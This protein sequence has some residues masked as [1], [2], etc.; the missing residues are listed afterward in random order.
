MLIVKEEKD[1]MIIM[2]LLLFPSEFLCGGFYCVQIFVLRKL[3][4]AM[5]IYIGKRKLSSINYIR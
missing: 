1:V 5:R 4:K 3:F 2:I